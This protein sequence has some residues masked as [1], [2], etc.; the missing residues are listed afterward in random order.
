MRADP[1]G[2]GLAD[3]RVMH[4]GAAGPEDRH[5]RCPIGTGRR[6]HPFGLGTRDRRP[7]VGDDR[8]RGPLAG[9]RPAVPRRSRA[10]IVLC[11]RTRVRTR[12]SRCR[13]RRWASAASGV[14]LRTRAREPASPRSPA[15]RARTLRRAS[16]G[17]V[18]VP[19][20]RRTAGRV[21]HRDGDGGGF[22]CNPRVRPTPAVPMSEGRRIRAVAASWAVRIATATDGACVSCP[23][24]V[25]SLRVCVG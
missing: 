22:G 1:R 16:I 7:R 10:R 5:G 14:G 20:A 24:G 15:T 11:S 18:V 23:D 13:I 25:P 19:W 2:A 4:D 12:R 3:P 8:Q 6:G 21:A 9:D 17:S